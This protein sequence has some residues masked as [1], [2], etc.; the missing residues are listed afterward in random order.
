MSISVAERRTDAHESSR[1]ARQW[2]THLVVQEEV[3]EAWD[4][5]G[6]LG[7]LAHG[8][9]RG[10]LAAVKHV[11]PDLLGQGSTRN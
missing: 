5:L 7:E 4:A 6:E 3:H 9:H 1:G 11:D 10:A 2:G 8:F